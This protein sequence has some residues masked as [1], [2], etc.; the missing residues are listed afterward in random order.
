MN[1]DDL[2]SDFQ[3]HIERETRENIERGLS[4]DAARAAA[5][6][7]FGNVARVTEDTYAVWRCLWL[8]RL[9]QDLRYALRGLRKSPGFTA[10]AIATLALGI[11]MNTVVFSVID[12][13]LLRPLPYPDAE[14]LVWL[15]NYS[16]QF[17]L[18]AVAGPDFFDWKERA[19]SFDKMASY[20]FSGMTVGAG[21]E[22]DEVGVA[23]V[24]DGFLEIT[25]ARPAIGRLFTPRDRNALLLSHRYFA[26]RF[27][28]D[29]AVVGKTVTINGRPFEICGVL[30]EIFRFDLPLQSP[31][32]DRRDIEAYIPETMTPQTQIR[33]QRMSILNV[34][35]RMKPGVRTGQALAELATIQADIARHDSS[36]FYR[37][38]QLHVTPLQ[39]QVV[40]G[41]RRGLLVLW[42][43][44]GFVLLIAFVNV[45][46]LMLGRATARRGEIA[47]RAAMG[48]GR[49]RMA[50][51]LMVEGLV[52]AIAG[53]AGGIAVARV[54]LGA[55]MRFVGAAVPRL[56]ESSLDMRVLAFTLL[57]SAATGLLFGIAP[58]FWLSEMNLAHVLKEGGRARSAGRMGMLTRRLLMAAELAVALV[59]LIGAGLMIR[60]SWRMNSRPAG[61]A[62]ERILTMKISLLGPA[63]REKPAQLAY[64]EQVIDRLARTPGVEAAGIGNARL[65]GTIEA[66]GIR[67][68]AN[69]APQTTYHTVSAGYFRALGMRLTAG[70]WL[71]DDEPDP[72]VAVNEALARQVFGAADPIGKRIRT[73]SA[74][75][76][77]VSQS[78]SAAPMNTM[79]TIV[80]VVADLRYTKLDAAPSPETYIPYRQASSTRGMDVVALTA[81]DPAALAPAARSA[82]A[83]IDPAQS[84]YDVE[85]LEHAL[86]DSIAP[87]RFHLLLLGIFASVALVLAIVGI[88]GVMAY[89]VAQRS[90]EIGVRMALGAQRGEVVGMMVRQGMLVA[91]C[92]MAVG[93]VAALALTRVM[94]T[95]LFDVRPTDPATFAAVC[96]ILAAAALLACCA[97]ALRAARVDPTIALRYE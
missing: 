86:A 82:I 48:A 79:A 81:G 75:G 25:G 58:V 20:T 2:H 51:Q 73:G 93:V 53:G 74:Q 41:S 68:P 90:H 47:I 64:F 65:R 4:S 71:T 22:S 76:M 94:A 29:P 55:V 56:G 9:L 7:K 24:S 37:T 23:T 43:A 39:E 31:N 27:G 6:R 49:A 35:A 61:F 97:P 44:V 78:G 84:V 50:A 72:V 60:S 16:E 88:Y 67:F 10:A 96:G 52:L 19:R 91:A 54:A 57:L 34:V 42:A 38:L 95:L 89:A 17:K 40:G 63:Y 26:R 8:E 33:G 13:V 15:A 70:R 21:A 62:P 66:E 5:M 1:L 36:G 45:A 85:T 59:L 28:G 92:G 14:R 69:Q 32:L 18:E 11:G 30:P 83:A 77:V 3:D 12:A 80:G 46:N 87:R